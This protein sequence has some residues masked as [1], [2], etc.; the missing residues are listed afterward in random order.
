MLELRVVINFQ[1]SDGWLNCFGLYTGGFVWLCIHSMK[2]GMNDAL[3]S[4]IEIIR[5]VFVF[6]QEKY[7]DKKLGQVYL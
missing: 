4:G 6:V 5:D 2:A 1:A 3:S 7:N